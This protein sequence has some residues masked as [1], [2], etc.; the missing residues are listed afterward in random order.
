VNRMPIDIAWTTLGFDYTE[1]RSDL[2][3]T[4][5][6]DRVEAVKNKLDEAKK[7]ARQLLALHHPDKGGDPKKFRRVS[8]AIQSIEATTEEF[9]RKMNMTPE[10]D[11]SKRPFIKINS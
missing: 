3:N 11:T 4:P 8:E 5:K 7:M 9:T 2:V 1:V 6:G 10:I